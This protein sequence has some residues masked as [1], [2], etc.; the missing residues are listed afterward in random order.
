[1]KYDYKYVNENS[2]IRQEINKELMFL[3]PA[4]MSLFNAETDAKEI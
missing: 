2:Q 3:G 1:M 4:E